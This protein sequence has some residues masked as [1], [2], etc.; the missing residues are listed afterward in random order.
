M[1]ITMNGIDYL[2]YIRKKREITSDY[3]EISGYTKVMCDNK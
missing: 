2:A 1:L 3:S